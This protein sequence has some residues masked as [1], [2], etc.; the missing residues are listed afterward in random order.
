MIFKIDPLSYRDIKKKVESIRSKNTRLQSV[1]VP[2]EEYIEFDLELDII[3]LPGFRDRFDIDGFL[4]L[5][6]TAIYISQELMDK[7][8]NRYRFTLAH[9]I[10]HYALHGNL[11]DFFRGKLSESKSSEYTENWK[12]FVLKFNINEYSKLE[13][14]AYDFAGILLVPDDELSVALAKLKK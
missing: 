14:Q 2:I 12:S 13:G 9:E 3:P 1:P 5:D 6:R 4:T 8:Y 10:G 7:Y 11:F